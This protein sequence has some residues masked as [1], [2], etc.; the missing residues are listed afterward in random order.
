MAKF[1]GRVG[2]VTH[3]DDQET[4]VVREEAMEK[5]YFGKVLEHSRR[6]QGSD[7]VTDDLQLGN[8]ISITGNDYAFRYASAI[9]YCEYMGCFWKVT[10]IKVKRPE[11][12]LTLG[13]VYNGKRQACPPGGAEEVCPQSLL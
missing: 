12:I 6:W 4:G 1:H 7:M 9:A 3:I 5:T 8:Q 2:F 10:G 11:I 13:G